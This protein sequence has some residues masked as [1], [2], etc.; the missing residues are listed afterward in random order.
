MSSCIPVLAQSRQKMCTFPT[1]GF[2]RATLSQRLFC[3]TPSPW[4][5]EIDF[6]RWI[7]AQPT[8]LIGGIILSP[9]IMRLLAEVWCI[10][11]WW[12]LSLI[13]IVG[14]RSTRCF[15]LRFRTKPVKYFENLEK[16]RTTTSGSHV[17]LGS[18]SRCWVGMELSVCLKTK[19]TFKVPCRFRWIWRL[20]SSSL[21]ADIA[22]IAV[23]G[24]SHLRPDW[25]WLHA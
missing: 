4:L 10:S 24:A 6:T 14:I 21:E 1:P 8:S 17:S 16:S 2:V 5:E 9:Q 13:F 18:P 7:T 20:C 19:K 12:M 11:C 22:I 3:L 25:P 15:L 23:R